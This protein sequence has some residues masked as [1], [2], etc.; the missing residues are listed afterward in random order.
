MA[1]LNAFGAIGRLLVFVALLCAVIGVTVSG[2]ARVALLITALSMLIPGAVFVLTGQRLGRVSGLDRSLRESGVVGV[3]SIAAIRETGVVINGSPV[4]EL[5]VD[6]DSPVHAPYRTEIRQRAPRWQSSGLAPGSRIG[7]VVDPA[8]PHHLAVD[9]DAT[10]EPEP[11]VATPSPR[12]D[13]SADAV[14]DLARVLRTGRRARAV[15]I[16]MRDV[17]DMSELGLVQVG[18]EGDDDRLFVVDMEVQQPGL[19][20]YEVR[21]VHPVPER[22][23]GRIGPRAELRVAVDRDDDQVVAIDWES[24]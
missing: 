2:E 22:L 8:D 21:V 11:A 12:P 24:S 14:G 1:F 9:W 6:I 5:E 13:E 19:A 4:L 3:G 10:P 17:G 18:S 7:V 23:A 15:V 16:S 20:P